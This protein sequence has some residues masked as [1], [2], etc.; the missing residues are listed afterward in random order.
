MPLNPRVRFVSRWKTDPLLS[1]RRRLDCAISTFR[2]IYGNKEIGL[3][4][5]FLKY[6]QVTV[7]LPS[8]PESSPHILEYQSSSIYQTISNESFL[9]SPTSTSLQSYTKIL[10]WSKHRNLTSKTLLLVSLSEV[11]T[12]SF[13]SSCQFRLI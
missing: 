8:N 4:F 13:D 7:I 11:A 6:M 12:N 1:P 2:S 10:Y 3:F 5:L 9:T